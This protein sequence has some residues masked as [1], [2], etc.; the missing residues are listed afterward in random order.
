MKTVFWDVTPCSLVE[1]HYVSENP[2]VSKINVD[3][4]LPTERRHHFQ[5]LEFKWQHCLT[6]E[7]QFTG[8]LNHVCQ[9]Y[10]V[11]EKFQIIVD[12][13]FVIHQS[14]NLLLELHELL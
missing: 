8:S 6:G 1:V 4:L 11:G 3:D 9:E 7:L 2:A 14:S 10:N 13:E 5:Y 12:A